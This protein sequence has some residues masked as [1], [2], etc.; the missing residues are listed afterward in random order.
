MSFRHVVSCFSILFESAQRRFTND[1]TTFDAMVGL[2]LCQLV[3]FVTFSDIYILCNKTA[4][5]CVIGESKSVY[6]NCIVTFF[7]ATP[8]FTGCSTTIT[9][10]QSNSFVGLTRLNHCRYVVV[11]NIAHFNIY[12]ISLSDI[13]FHRQ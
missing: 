1:I 9:Q 4:V 3:V 2:G 7:D 5:S 10:S 12:C 13:Q 6:T 8:Y 11:C